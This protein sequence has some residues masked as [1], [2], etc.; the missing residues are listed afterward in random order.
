MFAQFQVRR[1]LTQLTACCINIHSSYIDL[2]VDVLTLLYLVSLLLL[3][4]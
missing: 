2:P 4:G 3:L 1:V